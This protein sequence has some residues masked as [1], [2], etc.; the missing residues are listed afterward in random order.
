VNISKKK[1]STVNLAK[2][3]LNAITGDHNFFH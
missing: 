3:P 1:K 2:T